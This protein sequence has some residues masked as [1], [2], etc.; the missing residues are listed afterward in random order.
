[1]IK[2]PLLAYRFRA[3]FNNDFDILS[4]QLESFEKKLEVTNGKLQIEILMR[5]RSTADGSVE[6]AIDDFMEDGLETIRLDILDD[7]MD[8]VV[9]SEVFYELTI[10]SMASTFSYAKNNALCY[11]VVIHANRYDDVTGDIKE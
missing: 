4:L 2:T 11:N 8:S 7:S 9:R 3:A 5:F 6:Q 1:M 10:K